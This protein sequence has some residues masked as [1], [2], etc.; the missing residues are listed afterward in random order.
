[1]ITISQSG[2]TA[3]TLAALKEIKKDQM[4]HQKALS[5]CNVPESSLSRESDVTV[6]TNAGA[7][8]GVASTKCIYSTHH[9]NAHC[10]LHGKKFSLIKT[11]EKNFENESE[12]LP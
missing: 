7:E 2:E 1:M 5:V 11:Q 10:R 8:I 12:F 4:I 9:F 3:D 6:F